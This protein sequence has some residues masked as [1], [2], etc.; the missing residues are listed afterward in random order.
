MGKHTQLQLH[1]ICT[2]KDEACGSTKH[3]SG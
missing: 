2:D 1:V 3:S